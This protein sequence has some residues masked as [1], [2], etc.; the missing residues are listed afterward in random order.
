MELRKAIEQGKLDQFIP[1]HER[2]I[3]DRKASEITL[4]LM[5]EKSKEASA[6]SSPDDCDG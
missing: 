5:A 6:V 2:E 1:E 3:G 4:R